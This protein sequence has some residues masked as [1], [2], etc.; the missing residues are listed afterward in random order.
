LGE[1]LDEPFMADA[2]NV[3]RS[4]QRIIGNS[5]RDTMLNTPQGQALRLA[6]AGH[7]SAIQLVP[8]HPFAAGVLEGV[9]INNNAIQ[10]AG[11]LQGV[12]APDGVF[13]NLSITF[14]TIDTLSAHKITLNGLVG[15]YNQ[16]E[17]NRDA[18]GALVQVE[19]DPIR[20]GGN[21]GTGNVWVLSVVAEDQWDYGY[22]AIDIGGDLSGAENPFQHITDHRRVPQYR[23]KA[24]GDTNL[25]SFPMTLFK[26][27]LATTTLQTLLDQDCSLDAQALAWLGRLEALP[28]M[29]AAPARVEQAKQVYAS[30]RNVP[31]LELN[32]H[33]PDVQ[34]FCIQALA[35]TFGVRV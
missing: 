28:D 23:D 25:N 32:R 34:N 8:D 9:I 10:S 24:N 13:R 6:E 11:K 2:V 22:G 33:S 20:L 26:Q 30:Q 14:N 19:L 7:R 31:I 27:Q 29:A 5:I 18:S 12:F 35:K 16:I 4:N 1:V 15:S 3:K 21:V 17:G